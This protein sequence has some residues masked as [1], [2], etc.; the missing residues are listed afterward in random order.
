MEAGRVR[1]RSRRLS[2]DAR[3][4]AAEIDREHGAGDMGPTENYPS[5]SRDAAG[6]SRKS[7]E[8]TAP[9]QIAFKNVLFSTDFSSTADSALPYAVEIARRFGAT[10]HA[11]HVTQPEIYPLLPP[12]EWPRMA[13][14]E[15]NFREQGKQHLEEELRGLPHEILFRSGKVWQNIA[16]IIEDKQI[17]LIVL[18]T[19]GRTGVEK[20]L[21]GSVAEEI[22][23]RGECPVLTVGKGVTTKATHAAAADLNRIFYATDFSP[24]SLAAAPFAIALAKEHRAELLLMH[25]LENPEPGEVNSAFQ[26]LRDVIPLGTWLTLKPKY[27]VETGAPGKA[28]LSAAAN[29]NADLIVLGVRRPKGNLFAAR[30]F[31]RSIAYEVVAHAACP[32]LTVRG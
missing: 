13:R 21:I 31:T 32:V 18:G 19:H 11:L 5:T 2:H 15:E 6:P 4:G 25:A 8:L 12:S 20:A 1:K 23:R 9:N 30:H 10:I 28:I 27:I 3:V 24:E 22:F 29:Y 14:E 7:G 26:T 17:D 16:L